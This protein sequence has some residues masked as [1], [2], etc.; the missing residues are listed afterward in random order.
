MSSPAGTAL[1]GELIQVAAI[2]RQNSIFG[3]KIGNGIVD[4]KTG[5]ATCTNQSRNFATGFWLIQPQRYIGIERAS[6]DGKKFFGDHD[7]VGPWRRKKP[8]YAVRHRGST[9]RQ[10]E[11]VT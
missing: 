8:P 11:R 6:K 5:G 9:G 7:S 4:K 3:E 2:G 10:M 1:A